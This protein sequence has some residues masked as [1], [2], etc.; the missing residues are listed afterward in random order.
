MNQS[1]L[2]ELFGTKDRVAVI[3][4][5]GTGLGFWMAETWV[6]AGGRVW[7][8]GRR[9]DKLQEANAKLNS[10]SP[11]SANYVVADLSIK[12]GITALSIAVSARE[13]AV[14]ALVNNAGMSKIDAVT[15][16]QQ[17]A[18]E[19]GAALASYDRALWEE[20]YA[21]NV[22]AAGVLTGEFLPLL[23]AA[24]KK[25]DGRGSVLNISS[26]S[27]TVWNQFWPI[28]AYQTSKAG[29]IALTRIH[30]A[31]LAVH[32]VRVNSIQPG[33]F[34]TDMN[35]VEAEFSPGHPSHVDRIP[36]G[37]SGSAE[38]IGGTFL[39]L[40]GKA[41]AYVT[42]SNFA[43]DGGALLVLNNAYSPY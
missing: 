17:S 2:E 20:L 7:I 3:T 19:M 32:G 23:A 16:P 22:W 12:E 1:Y 36:L 5:G 43:V 33:S 40:A 18:A 24:A 39:Y 21:L 15:F 4:G 38:D 6:K 30:A 8:S 29:L 10:L 25:G 31:K 27:A 34:P 41:G 28:Q 37:G 35:P 14:D 26:T 11:D 42:G 13:T 9:E